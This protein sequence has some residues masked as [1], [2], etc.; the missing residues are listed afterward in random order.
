MI[1]CRRNGLD[2]TVSRPALRNLGGQSVDNFLLGAGGHPV[3]DGLV[4]Q[5]LRVTLSD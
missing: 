5:H 3:V 4:G 2:E 1:A